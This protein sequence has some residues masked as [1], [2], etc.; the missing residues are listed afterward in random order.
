MN[1][2]MSKTFWWAL[3][4][5]IVATAFEA[6]QYQASSGC[7]LAEDIP[8]TTAP[9]A[10]KTLKALLVTGGCCHDY[11]RQ[12]KILTEGISARANVQWEIVHQGKQYQ[13][14]DSAL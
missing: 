2:V 3:S 7:A 14:Q 10:A 13:C 1:N 9:K 8:Q 11:Q 6:N 5:L 4:I 12:K